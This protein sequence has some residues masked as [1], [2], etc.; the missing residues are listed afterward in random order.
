MLSVDVTT[1]L[2]VGLLVFAGQ[3]SR[4]TGRLALL[5]LLSPALRYL[6]TLFTFS[7]RLTLSAWAGRLL[8]LTGLDVD[9]DGNVLVRNGQAMSVDPA[10]M[11][12]QMTGVSLLVAM[13][14]LIWYE[15]Q[16]AK[17]VPFLW[18]V[19][20]G[21]VVFGFT[22]VCNLFRIILLVAFGIPPD[23]LGHDIVG[24]LCVAMYTWLPTW[25]VS[26]LLI[27][28]RGRDQKPVE[29]PW[30]SMKWSLLG[31]LAG[32]GLMAYTSRPTQVPTEPCALKERFGYSDYVCKSLDN[33]FV[34]LTKTGI[35]IYLKPLSDWYSLEH[36]PAVCWRG[37]G[38]ELRYIRETTWGGH[39]AY[40][41]ELT[42]H[43]RTLQTMWWFSDG[44]YTTISQLDVRSRMLRGSSG[45]ALV[46]VT[47]PLPGH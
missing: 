8:R 21:I 39:P 37:S 31:L 11:G 23:T 25:G 13:F 24:L 1:C 6:S 34:Q 18:V 15:K 29:R 44:S 14:L 7:I 30:A 9:V 36:N 17:Q 2:T 5:L 12:L 47:T 41:G 43:G 20:Y 4:W 3:R 45:F 10:C 26:L 42:K 27:R 38:Y 40:V 19:I 22:I 16:T 35:L 33:G 32:F 46:N 28:W